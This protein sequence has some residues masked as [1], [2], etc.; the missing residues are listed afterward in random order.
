MLSDRAKKSRLPTFS[1]ADN[2]ATFIGSK[3][4]P[5]SL[6]TACLRQDPKGILFGTGEV[7]SEIFTKQQ[8]EVLHDKLYGKKFLI[9][10]G[11]S[12]KLV[13]YSCAEPFLGWFKEAA[14]SR[15]KE[16]KIEVDDR[17]YE[18]IGHQFSAEMVDDA[19]RFVVDAVAG[20]GADSTEL[21]SSKI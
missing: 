14:G 18:G 17:V 4:F 12:D 21:R 20:A 10:S 11:G 19:V 16:E 15:F 1:A 5:P 7:P 13:P 2:G 8:Q 9:C 6:V 3:D